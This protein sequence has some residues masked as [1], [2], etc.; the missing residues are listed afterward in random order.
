MKRMFMFGATFLLAASLHA[1]AYCAA[2]NHVIITQLITGGFQQTNTMQYKCF[3]SEGG[4]WIL[5]YLAQN[6]QL[7]VQF[8]SREANY[9]WQQPLES[10]QYTYS[11]CSPDGETCWQFRQNQVTNQTCV[12]CNPLQ[13]FTY[14]MGEL[15]FPSSR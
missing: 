5:G 12:N 14:F 8:A 10:G 2:S 15:T 1:A 11:G 4:E 13:Q 9:Q 3:L 7:S 6:E